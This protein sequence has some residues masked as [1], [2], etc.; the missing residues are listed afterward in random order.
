MNSM[1]SA[2]NGKAKIMVTAQKGERPARSA[3]VWVSW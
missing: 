2:M 1:S 3:G